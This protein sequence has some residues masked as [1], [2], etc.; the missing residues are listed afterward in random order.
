[1]QGRLTEA[2]LSSFSAYQHRPFGHFPFAT[3][4][5]NVDRNLDKAVAIHLSIFLAGTTMD[6]IILHHYPPSLFSEKVR[7]LLGYLGLPWRS[8][9][10]PP[11]MPR[12]HLI[13][14]SGGYRKTPI[15]QIGA[16]I[17]CDTE[18]ICRTLNAMSDRADIYAPGFNAERIARWADTELFKITVALNFRPE[19][20]AA[21]MSQMSAS[22]LEAFQKDR[23]ELAGG[24]ALV[25]ISPEAAL[26][27]F[28]VLM[29]QLSASLREPFL[30]GET[31]C[32]AD[33]SVYHCLWFVA[34]NAANARLLDPWPMV[35]AFV[36][37]MQAFQTDAWEDLSAESALEIGKSAEPR[38]SRKSQ[39]IDPGLANDLTVGTA[40][41]VT[42]NDYGRIPVTGAL[43]SWTQHAIVIER[44]DPVAGTVAVHFPSIGFEVSRA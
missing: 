11:M 44:E 15:M 14:L 18:I 12:P 22:D 3:A 17:F 6:S 39:Q 13:P 7:A 5:A 16:D 26:A 23:A 30:F 8:V 25:S 24:Q 20:I 31:P 37:R 1:M 41:A 29:E 2:Q 40:I 32:I 27:E 35:Q 38:L 4:I 19:A 43:Q 28:K 33:F 10:I 34:G 36:E 42:P 9:I 21:Q